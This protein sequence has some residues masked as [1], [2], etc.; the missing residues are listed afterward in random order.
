MVRG[1]RSSLR[2]LAERRHFP[3]DEA[4]CFD[5]LLAAQRIRA[6]AVPGVFEVVY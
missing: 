6:T 2:Y 1:A 4:R 5:Q 3:E